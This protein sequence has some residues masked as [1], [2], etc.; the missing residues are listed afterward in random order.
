MVEAFFID[1]A[2]FV[3]GLLCLTVACGALFAVL[4]F[5]AHIFAYVMPR[6]GLKFVRDYRNG[7]MPLRQLFNEMT[8]PTPPALPSNQEYEPP[9]DRRPAALRRL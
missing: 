2:I 4:Q 8:D 9:A 7:T 3:L 1:L 5:A 6:I